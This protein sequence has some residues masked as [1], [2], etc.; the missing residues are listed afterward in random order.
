MINLQSEIIKIGVALAIVASLVG[1]HYIKVTSLESDLAQLEKTHQALVVA[2]GIQNAEIKRLGDLSN[3][4]NK[5]VND[6]AKK[7]SEDRKAANKL[8]ADIMGKTIPK[9]CEGALNVL[10]EYSQQGAAKWNQK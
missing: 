9:D 7:N 6:A 3:E 5:L 4:Y 2:S 8:I 1:Y 10:R